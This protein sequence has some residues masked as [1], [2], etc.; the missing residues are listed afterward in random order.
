VQGGIALANI[1]LAWP[2]SRGLGPWPGL[3]F[4]GVPLG[5][6]ISYLLGAVAVL[7]VLGQGRAGLKLS[8]DGFRPERGLLRRILRV[9]VPAG[10][11][12]LSIVAGQ[13]WFLHIVNGLGDAAAA[14][15][16][17]AIGW[18]AL[19]YL[20]GHAFG[21]A[22]MTLVG[23]ALGA[24]QPALAARSGWVAFGLGCGVMSLMGVVFFVLAPIMF[25]V[26]CQDPGQW[27]VIEAGVRVL[28]LVAFAMPALASTIIFTAALRGAGDTRV[29]VLFTWV[30]FLAVRIPLAYVLTD[31]EAVGLG[32][33]G[34]WLAMSA[35]LFVRGVFFWLRFRSGK[36]QR[37]RV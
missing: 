10:I 9:S 8:L 21:T 26:F 33:F 31:E 12:S 14:A 29:P 11:D 13:L 24:R 23:Q 30:G 36:W 3:G 1:G 18:E 27:P 28:R 20:S 5:T 6:G 22:A 4:V 35:D 17:I 25:W 19:G 15:H 7:T 34:A 32:L 37:A 2:L 16:G